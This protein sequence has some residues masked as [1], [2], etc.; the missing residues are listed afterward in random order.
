MDIEPKDIFLVIIGWVI[1]KMLDYVQ[2]TIRN[3]VSPSRKGKNNG[4]NSR[5]RRKKKQCRF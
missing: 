1:T 4:Y 3:M 2:K 5:R